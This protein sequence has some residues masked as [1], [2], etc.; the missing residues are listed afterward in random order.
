MPMAILPTKHSPKTQQGLTLIEVLIALAIIS[1]ALTAVIKATSHSIRSTAYLE[2]KAEANWVAQQVM[3]EIRVGVLK[4]PETAD[5]ID[6]STQMLGR[7]W[8]WSASQQAT[9][10]RRIKK[11]TVSVYNQASDNAERS[12]IITLESY[13]YDAKN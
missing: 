8:Y 4:L 3:N 7:D 11:I 12:S 2:N 9:P 6:Q 5:T 10:N 13:T 1:I